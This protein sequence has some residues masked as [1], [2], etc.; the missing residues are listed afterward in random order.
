MTRLAERFYYRR[1]ELADVGGN[2]YKLRLGPLFF[3]WNTL[4]C[5][6]QHKGGC[7]HGQT[8][9]PWWRLVAFSIVPL[10]GFGWRLWFYWRTGAMFVDVIRDRKGL[11][12]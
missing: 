9:W 7:A 8:S 6:G 1:I 3:E 5:N 2:I 4:H 10:S 12:W 11:V